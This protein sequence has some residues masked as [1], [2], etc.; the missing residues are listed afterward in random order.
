ML[1]WSESESE[2]EPRPI[3]H[4]TTC[5]HVGDQDEF[6]S[7]ESDVV[8]PEIAKNPSPSPIERNEMCK[9]KGHRE[10]KANKA[11]ASSS[12]STN[13]SDANTRETTLDG[14]RL[15]NHPKTHRCTKGEES[16]SRLVGHL[17]KLGVC[18][19]TAEI[20]QMSKRKEPPERALLLPFF[21]EKRRFHCIIYSKHTHQS[22]KTVDRRATNLTHHETPKW[23]GETALQL[24]TTSDRTGDNNCIIM[25]VACKPCPS[26]S[27][28]I[29][30]LNIPV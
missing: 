18:S 12:G 6:D 9:S 15:E 28:Q 21:V 30:N 20:F 2:S 1:S 23:D 13:E 27:H 17:T 26:L 7:E 16:G 11:W 4:A 24:T 29:L 19:Y 14:M 10:S 3:L 25:G 8:S 5:F 22:T